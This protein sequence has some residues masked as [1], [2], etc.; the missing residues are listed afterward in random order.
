M[1]VK[2]RRY[3]EGK[4]NYK[5]RLA[6]V[7]SGL[8]RLVIRKHHNSIVAQV[9]SYDPKGDKVL[10]G[11]VSTMLKKYGWD[12][13]TGNIPSAYLTGYA[14]GLRAR[15]KGIK[16]MVLDLGLQRVTKGSSLFACLRGVLDAGIDVPHGEDVLP[17]EDRLYGG[18]ISENI[19]SKIDE[20]KNKLGE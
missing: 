2:Y 10:T 6:L 4:T 8:P 12:A 11:F 15:K 20:V 14:L 1:I 9:V 13:H 5:K 18:H 7:K 3:R 17:K 19:K 16:R